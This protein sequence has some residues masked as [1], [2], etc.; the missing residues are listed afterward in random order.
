LSRDQYAEKNHKIKTGNKF[1]ESV[2][3]VRYLETTVTIQNSI[4]DE[5]KNVMKV[6][7]GLQSFTQHEYSDSDVETSV[8]SKVV[9][10]TAPS[11]PEHNPFHFVFNLVFMGPCIVNQCQ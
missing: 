1:F 10:F 8:N 11:A 6:R 4:H 3:K 9:F 7:E 2:E 5:I